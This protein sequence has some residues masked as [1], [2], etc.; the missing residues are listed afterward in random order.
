MPQHPKETPS[1]PTDEQPRLD[2]FSRDDSKMLSPEAEQDLVDG[3]IF[4]KGAEPKS[5][6]ERA[7]EAHRRGDHKAFDEALS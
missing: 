2:L 5:R 7:L 3:M 6:L 4:T 1:S